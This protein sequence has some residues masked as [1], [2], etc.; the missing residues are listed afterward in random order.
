MTFKQLQYFV[1]TVQKQ[2]FKYASEALFI[3]APALSQQIKILEEELDTTLIN[4]SSHE[5]KL[6]PSG[7]FLYERATKILNEFDDMLNGLQQFSSDSNTP[8]IIGHIQTPLYGQTQKAAQ[9]INRD[10]PNISIEFFPCEFSEVP[11]LL[12]NNYIDVSYITRNYLPEGDQFV[13]VPLFKYEYKM[14]ISSKHPLTSLDILNHADIQNYPLVVL[15][16]KHNTVLFLEYLKTYF[17]DYKTIFVSSTAELFQKLE[18]T[19]GIGILPSYLCTRRTDIKSYPTFPVLDDNIGVVYL[20][21]NKKT[22]LET[23]VNSLSETFNMLEFD[24]MSLVD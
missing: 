2:S 22:T 9:I 8:I 15:Q 10:Y 20:S 19:K 1:Y 12:L 6:T 11:S 17:K 7:Q 13:F 23:V 14:I 4:R 24:G 16:N 5:F 21:S 18:S 3:S